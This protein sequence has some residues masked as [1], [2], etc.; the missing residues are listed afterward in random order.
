MK[1]AFFRLLCFLQKGTTTEYN[2]THTLK[3]AFAGLTGTIATKISDSTYDWNIPTLFGQELSLDMSDQCRIDCITYN[4]D[5]E[6]G[7][8]SCTITISVPSGSNPSVTIDMYASDQKT[9]DL[10]G[11]SNACIIGITSL[12]YTVNATAKDGAYIYC[13]IGILQNRIVKVKRL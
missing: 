2:Y 13:I 7:T 1:P 4:G 8:K 9:L 10:A 12:S 5:T 3:W 6:L 11:K